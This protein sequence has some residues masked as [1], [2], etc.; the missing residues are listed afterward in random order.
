[1]SLAGHSPSCVHAP[2]IPDPLRWS[3]NQYA[4][5]IHDCSHI[6][7]LQKFCHQLYSTPLPSCISE[8][9]V[10]EI[11]HDILSLRN[12]T[13]KYGSFWEEPIMK[14]KA[15]KVDKCTTVCLATL[16]HASG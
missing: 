1:M 9:E 13:R 6:A 2:T 7:T 12:L 15:L 4:C 10:H 16:P 8:A 3:R 14:L 5:K 11:V